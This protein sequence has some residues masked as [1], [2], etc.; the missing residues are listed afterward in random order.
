MTG[1]RLR[2]VGVDLLKV[3]TLLRFCASLKLACESGRLSERSHVIGAH[4]SSRVLE[5]IDIL[6][7]HAVSWKRR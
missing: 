7:G 5:I 1:D 6:R 4:Q 3:I 2:V